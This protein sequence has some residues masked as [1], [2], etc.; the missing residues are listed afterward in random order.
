MITIAWVTWWTNRLQDMGYKVRRVQRDGMYLFIWRWPDGKLQAGT[1]HPDQ[2]EAYCNSLS[3]V[4][5]HRVQ[6]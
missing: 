5:R 6:L 2:A 4:V 1:E 3:Q